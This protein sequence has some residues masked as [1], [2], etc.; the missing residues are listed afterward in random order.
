MS[1]DLLFIHAS[2][3]KQQRV[4]L[5]EMRG[6]NPYNNVC[7]RRP[8][9]SVQMRSVVQFTRVVLALLHNFASYDFRKEWTRTDVSRMGAHVCPERHG[10]EIR[11]ERRS[12]TE[13]NA[14]R[15]ERA[16]SAPHTRRD[17]TSRRYRVC[18]VMFANT[19]AIVITLL[20]DRRGGFERSVWT[21]NLPGGGFVQKLLQQ[22]GC[23]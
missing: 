19:P 8:N 1:A 22:S 23:D 15:R 6:D 17:I 14:K 21:I 10:N 2:T 16:Q 20:G 5:S 7:A 13:A 18:C 4:H 9:S 11:T 3:Q 12:A